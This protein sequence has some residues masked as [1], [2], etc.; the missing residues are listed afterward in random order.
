MFS[1]LAAA[2]ATLPP[3]VSDVAKTDSPDRE[4]ATRRAV[5]TR[6]IVTRPARTEAPA[7]M[8]M[9]KLPGAA[10]PD[11]PIPLNERVLEYVT[12]FQTKLRRTIEEG[13]VRGEQYFPMIQGV[14]RAEG[15]PLDLAYMPLIESVFEPAA[16]SRAQAKGVWQLTRGTA[17]A[18]GLEIN[19]LVDE[20][21]DPEKATRAAARYL[22]TLRDLFEGDWLLA[23]ASYNGGPGRVARA[24]ERAG[25]SD[26]W[27]LSETTR[28]LPRETREY[29]P[30]ILAAMLVA[31]NPARYGLEIAD[32]GPRRMRPSPSS[33]RSAL[34]A[35]PCGPRLNFR[36]AFEQI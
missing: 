30:K 31:R 5:A 28:Y 13:L 25:T 21:A 36:S 26:F 14:L 3:A 35:S 16:V 8:T 19:E 10:S 18:H 33:A 27:H 11:I 34:A 32:A 7:R 20:R 29:V 24:V 6:E 9:D 1:L 2:C 17:A 4:Q 22:K 12:R 15:L 23:L